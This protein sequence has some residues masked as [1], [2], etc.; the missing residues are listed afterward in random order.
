MPSTAVT[1]AGFSTHV[2]VSNDVAQSRLST[3][4]F[5]THITRHISSSAFETTVTASLN[6]MSFTC[7]LNFVLDP[8][9]HSCDALLGLDWSQRCGSVEM[10]SL[11]LNVERL[12]NY[13]LLHQKQYLI[14]YRD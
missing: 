5:E 10:Q 11:V 14:I 7:V 13:F 12:L 4:F 8:C 2:F 6:L 1:V 9:L 3:Q